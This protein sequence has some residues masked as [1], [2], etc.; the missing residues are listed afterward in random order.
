MVWPRS[1][2]PLFGTRLVAH[3]GGAGEG[4]ADGLDEQAAVVLE[5]VA[6]LPGQALVEYP[7]P[8]CH[9]L[10]ASIIYAR[11]F[12]DVLLVVTKGGS[13]PQA[14]YMEAA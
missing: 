6:D 11:R 13:I 8:L 3:I 14:V 4:L 7:H 10:H 2:F 12:R 9:P 1:T 5:T